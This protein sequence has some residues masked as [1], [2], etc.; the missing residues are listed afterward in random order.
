MIKVVIIEDEDLL[1]KGLIYTF[2]WKEMG[3]IIIGEAENGVEGIRIIEQL[4]PDIVLVDIQMPRMDGLTML[5]QLGVHPFETIIMTGYAEFE[6]AKKAIDLNVS[7]FLLKPI[8]DDKL[9]SIIQ[10]LK[11]KIEDK[12]AIQHLKQSKSSLNTD[13]FGKNHDASTLYSSH[14]V[15]RKIIDYIHTHYQHRISLQHIAQ[16]LQMSPSYLSRTFKQITSYSVNDYINRYRITKAIELLKADQYRLY[17]IA[18][19]VGFSEYKY[20]HHVF[21]HYMKH[22]PKA[23]LKELDYETATKP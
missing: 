20:F 2:D 9:I 4:N 13:L 17:E 14:K 1:R 7:H 22:S 6:Y 21:V 12:K 16:G 8:E 11:V 15:V 18:E 23:F 19:M 3:C 10:D 5:Q